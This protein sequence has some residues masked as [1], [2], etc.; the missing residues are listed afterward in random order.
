MTPQ[1]LHEINHCINDIEYFIKKYFK[2]NNPFHGVSTITLTEKQKT[3]LNRIHGKPCIIDAIPERQIGASTVYVASVL[4]E[5]LFHSNQTLAIV[6]QSRNGCKH[7]REMIRTAYDRLPEFMKP[8]LTKNNVHLLEFDHDSR[9][10]LYV[11]SECMLRGMTIQQVFFEDFEFY[12][13]DVK[14]ACYQYCDIASAIHKNKYE[15]LVI[16]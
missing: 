8:T 7:V 12:R 4:W 3:I 2:V 6:S 5:A 1:E 10:V 15:Q 14:R 9:I 11:A 16:V 13:K